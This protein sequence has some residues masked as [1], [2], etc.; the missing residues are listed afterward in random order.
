MSRVGRAPINIPDKVTVEFKDRTVFVAGPLGK[1]SQNIPDANID[2]KFENNQVLVTRANDDKA[3]KAKHGLYRVL[4]GNMVRG[5]TQPFTKTLIVNGVGFKCAV[6]G[7]KL[8][9]LGGN[10]C[11]KTHLAISI[12]KKTGGVIYTAFKIGIMI[13][14]SFKE[15][16][17]E[18]DLYD[19]LCSAPLLIID[20]VE[21]IKDSDAKREW[22]AHVVG[23]RYN[24][25]LPMIFIANCHSE[26]DCREVQ[27]PC[28]KCLEYHLENE[29]I[30]RIVDG[31]IILKFNSDDY[32]YKKRDMINDRVS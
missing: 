3:V 27:K 23:E 30:S 4:I 29:I 21:K 28:K 25:K 26:K 8:V 32:R 16:G 6:S 15:F 2:V 11:G 1:L 19:K 5:V 10:G 22:F 18:A 9:M 7:K 14:N 13:R 24:Q 12:L 20:E 17:M 31:G